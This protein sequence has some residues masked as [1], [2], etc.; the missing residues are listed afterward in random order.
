[1]N[2][3]TKIL[4]DEQKFPYFDM[5]KE[6][7]DSYLNVISHCK[8][9]YET[10]NKLGSSSKCKMHKM[11]LRKQGSAVTFNGILSLGED[12]IYENRCIRG[13]L[14]VDK[15]MILVYMNVERLGN[16]EPKMYSV[17]DK[18]KLQ[19]DI[20]IRKTKYDYINKDI[21]EEVKDEKVKGLI[22]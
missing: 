2:K 20:L 14:Y 21:I 8:D 19:N 22:K 1:M 3:K 7:R 18:F 5:S 6:E 12:K 17:A 11:V 15:D 10:E 9:I 4:L 16:V 13:E